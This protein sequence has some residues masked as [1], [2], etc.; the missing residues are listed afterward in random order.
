MNS[1]IYWA[2]LSVALLFFAFSL[3]RWSVSDAQRLRL[4][5]GQYQADN[6]PI[7]RLPGVPDEFEM[8]NLFSLD[9]TFIATALPESR[10]VVYCAEMAGRR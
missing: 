10:G 2:M 9:S 4:N 3:G 7:I 1:K 8:V 5:N 6:G